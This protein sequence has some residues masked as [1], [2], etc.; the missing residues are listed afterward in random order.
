MAFNLGDI[1]VTFKAKTDDL[2]RGVQE[3]KKMTDTVE[4]SAKSTSN[5]GEKLGK[6]AATTAKAITAVAAAATTATI[7]AT[8]FAV[9]SAAEFEQTRIGLENM[10]GS[11]DKARS[12]LKDISVFAAETPFEFPELA[13]SVKQLVAFGFSGED[14][15]STMK[16]LGDVSAAIGA[17]IGDLS[18]L[19]GTLKT[20]GRAF[21]IDIRQFAQRGIPIYEYLASTLGKTTQ[22]ISGMI[23]EGKIGFPEVQAAFKAMTSEGGKFHGTMDKQSKS[24]SGLW[25]TLKDNIGMAARE[26]VGINSQGDIRDNSIFDY[27]RRGVSGLNDELGKI[28]WVETVQVA[29]EWLGKLYTSF[30]DVVRAVGDYLG[31]K[32]VDL[33]NSFSKNIIPILMQLWNDVIVPLLPVIGTAL[34]LAIGAVVDVLKTLFDWAGW[35]F[36]QLKDGNPIIWAL[37]GAFGYLAASMVLNSLFAALSAG[38]TTLSTVIIP[39]AIASFS[40]FIAVI[41]GPMAVAAIGIGAI[42]AVI[43]AANQATQALDNMQIA[44]GNSDKVTED[45]RRA[46]QAAKQRGDIDKYNKLQKVYMDSLARNAQIHKEASNINFWTGLQTGLSQMFALGTPSAPGGMALV[47]ENGPEMA[48]LPGGTTVRSNQETEA[49]LKNSGGNTYNF[50]LNGVFARSDSEL[51]DMMERGIKALDRRLTAQGKPKILGGN[52]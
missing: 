5:F 45:I 2:K 24:L 52:A 29:N 26:I 27:L 35:V 7:A 10:L 33:Y 37:T 41:T 40:S 15:I 9:K 12:V 8:S 18:Y 28:D 25:S 4:K 21:T 13:G 51:A 6:M 46:A 47:G 20:Q 23:E 30:M 48:F 32:L 44:M 1:L 42:T 3:V 38:F 31:P 39:A 50:D 14:A 36:Q 11:A 16:Q 22:E 17:P 43:N 49:L 34:V 19:M